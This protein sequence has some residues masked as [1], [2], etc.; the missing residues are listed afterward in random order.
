MKN[1]LTCILLCLPGTLAAADDYF[2]R[3]LYPDCRK[4]TPAEVD[5]RD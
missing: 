4:L 5:P 2:E 3:S 1:T